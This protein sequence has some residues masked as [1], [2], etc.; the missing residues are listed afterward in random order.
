MI[1]LF[2]KVI[3]AGIKEININLLLQIMMAKMMDKM[4]VKMMAGIEI[5]IILLQM[6]IDDFK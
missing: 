3:M 6:I 2:I 1:I 4:M 5:M